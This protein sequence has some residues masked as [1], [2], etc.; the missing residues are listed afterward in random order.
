MT[1]TKAHRKVK[2]ATSKNRKNMQRPATSIEIST[3]AIVHFEETPV[4]EI[5]VKTKA[6][7][8][9]EDQKQSQKET[10]SFDMV[11]VNDRM[12]KRIEKTPNTKR[13]TLSAK[14]IKDQE[15]KKAISA[16]NR[17]ITQQKKKHNYKK[18]GLGFRRA[19]LAT[20]CAAVAV[21]AIAYFVNLNSPDI[22]LKVAAMQ[23]GISAHYPEYIPRDFTLSDIT[24]ENGKVA[25][26]FKNSS[27]NEKFSLAEEAV[28]WDANDL[29]INFVRANYGDDYNVISENG[30]FIYVS[31]SNAA[32][33]DNGIFY[34]IT[35]TDGVLTK[36]QISAIAAK[37]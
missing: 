4:Q 30:L 29:Y 12:R 22:S 1:S 32:W 23:S 13:T 20:A 35:A 14:E 26:N 28:N 16:T 21:F 18:M 2:V 6:K 9:K 37:L 19:I 27:T 8:V 17:S 3:P 31:G 34:K 10:L 24:S 25:I 5:S 15:I 11:R 36:K 7:I 33:V